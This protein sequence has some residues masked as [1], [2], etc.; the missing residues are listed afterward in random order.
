M[1]IPAER[2]D[3]SWGHPRPRKGDTWF[4][5]VTSG[6]RFSQWQ[7]RRAIDMRDFFNSRFGTECTDGMSDLR[8]DE[9]FSSK[10]SRWFY[11]VRAAS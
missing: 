10:L 9:L 3:L 6:W 11:L 1:A 2:E 7:T 5:L 8:G 4:Y